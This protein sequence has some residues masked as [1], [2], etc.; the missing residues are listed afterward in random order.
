MRNVH[1]N[2]S[3]NLEY[4]ASTKLGPKQTE[5]TFQHFTY[6]IDPLHFA[7]LC[8]FHQYIPASKPFIDILK[9]AYK[10]GDWVDFM[11]QFCFHR[12]PVLLKTY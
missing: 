1:K 7:H 12:R 11:T 8:C 9:R 10:G 4:V 5:D 2:I 6:N 3:N